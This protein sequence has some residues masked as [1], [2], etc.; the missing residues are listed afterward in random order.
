MPGAI[1]FSDAASHRVYAAWA[2]T[3]YPVKINGFLRP[4]DT[5]VCGAA[6][7]GIITGVGAEQTDDV[8][9]NA[10]V[11][12]LRALEE[13]R[14]PSVRAFFGLAATQMRRELLDLARR[15]QGR[16]GPGTAGD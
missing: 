14:P 13:V 9:Q 1:S 15:Y 5:T 3:A 7:A 2:V 16:G 6:T 11:R 10:V 4:G 12:L 8:L